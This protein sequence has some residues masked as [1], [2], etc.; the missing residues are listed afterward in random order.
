MYEKMNEHPGQAQV[1]ALLDFPPDSVVFAESMHDD[2]YL[3]VVRTADG[4]RLECIVFRRVDDAWVRV[5]ND[6]DRTVAMAVGRDPIRSGLTIPIG[7]GDR[8]YDNRVTDDGW[9]AFVAAVSDRALP[10]NKIMLPAGPPGDGTTPVALE[11]LPPVKSFRVSS[12]GPSRAPGTPE[13]DP[14]SNGALDE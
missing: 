5:D 14:E 12:L 4:E 11:P 2:L 1:C 10:E 3:A 7:V 6:A 13:E 8:V 9:W